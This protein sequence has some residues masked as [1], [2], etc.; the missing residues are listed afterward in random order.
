M[1]ALVKHL[2]T[3]HP[4]IAGTKELSLQEKTMTTCSVVGPHDV[5]SRSDSVGTGVRSVLHVN[6][7]KRAFT[8]QE[9]TITCSAEVPHDVASGVDP[10]GE[11]VVEKPSEN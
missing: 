2:A 11:G 5:A 1:H 6:C 7:G 4:E 8:K 9:T 3:N 10:L